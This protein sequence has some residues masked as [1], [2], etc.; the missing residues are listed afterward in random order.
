MVTVTLTRH[1]GQRE[2]GV[3]LRLPTVTDR[4]ELL[5]AWRRASG[6]TEA[7]D[8][9]A[10]AEAAAASEQGRDPATLPPSGVP[11][12]RDTDAVARA[13]LGLSLPES[14]GMPRL[15]DLRHDVLAY[16]DVV[17]DVLYARD[18]TV[19][20]EHVTEGMRALDWIAP[21]LS[22]LGVAKE[23]EAARFEQT[24]GGAARPS[25]GS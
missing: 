11:S 20:G 3:V 4:I 25:S 19:L 2:A 23:R 13:A 18:Y 17:A 22:R 9:A 5:R 15:R 8:A 12:D 24:P 14:W 10:H 1:T 6:Y 21:T 7:D 16:G